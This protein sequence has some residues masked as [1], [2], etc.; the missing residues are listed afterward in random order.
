MS[1]VVLS[2]EK[3]VDT[4]KSVARKLRRE[5][6]VPGVLYGGEEEPSSISMDKIE[7][8]RLL[9]KDHSI[10]NVKVDGADQRAVIRDVQNHPVYGDVA[11]ID[12]MRVVAGQEI[13]ISVPLHQVGTAVGTKTGGQIATLLHELEISV[14]PRY[15][16]ENIEIDI[17]DLEIGDA[18]RVKDL[19]L[20][21]MTIQNDEDELIVQVTMPRKEEEPEETDELGEEEESMEPEVIT[22]RGDDDEKESE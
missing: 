10:I 16:P 3:R 11:H 22:A 15:M 4:G 20:E 13:T 2:A 14:L 8:G 5:G 6:K 19:N 18:I 12:F 21:N 17:T 1:E 7:L 9:R